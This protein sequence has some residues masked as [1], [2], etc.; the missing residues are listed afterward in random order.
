M[1]TGSIGGK[2]RAF[3]IS[4]ADDGTNSLWELMQDTDGQI[5]DKAW[6]CTTSALVDQRPTSYFETRRCDFGHANYRKILERIDLHIS[7]LLGRADVKVEYRA[8]IAQKWQLAGTYTFCAQVN[9]PVTA[10]E[11]VHIWKNLNPQHR[12]QVKTFTIPVVRDP[13]IRR[14]TNTG[15]Q[16]QIRISWQGNML[17]HRAVAHARPLD[18]EQY[19]SPLDIEDVC[20]ANDVT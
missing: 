11:S 5:A 1:F 14:A 17:V 10:G 20:S 12:S 18:Q 7:E 13:I 6:S 9:D 4:C 15:F 8:D 16:F 2:P 19:A 3:A